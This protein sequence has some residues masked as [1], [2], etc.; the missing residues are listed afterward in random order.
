MNRFVVS[1]LIALGLAMSACSSDNPKTAGSS[2]A[3]TTSA[4][5]STST[6]A[7]STTSTSGSCPSKEDAASFSVNSQIA[8]QFV[9]LAVKDWSKTLGSLDKYGS[10]IDSL[11]VVHG[12]G[13]SAALD[14]F[15]QANTIIQKG[16]G[17]DAT[18]TD[19]LKQLLGTDI[20][21]TL[22]KKNTVLLAYGT[23]CP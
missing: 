20:A 11:R 19:Q 4:S 14:T 21:E 6:S 5:T 9:N 1:G 3:P 12:D 18:A 15:A 23:Q 22:K 2:A 7:S 16:F 13:V 17:G 8:A 10:Q